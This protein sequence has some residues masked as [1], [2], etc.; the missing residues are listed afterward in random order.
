M[1]LSLLVGLTLLYISGRAQVI[2]ASRQANWS[3]ALGCYNYAVP[4]TELN[5]MDFGATGN[6]T[7]NDQPAVMAAIA[8]LNGHLGYIYFPPGNYLLNSPITLPDSVVLKG[9]SSDSTTLTFNFA[10]QPL[11]G[12]NIYGTYDPLLIQLNAGYVKDN[13]WVITDSAFL[14]EPGDYVEIIQNNGPWD[15]VPAEWAVNSV[16]QILRVDHINGDTIY[17]ESPLRI[18]Y[19]SALNPRMRKIFPRINAGVECIKLKRQDAAT[20]GANIIFS[21]AA[22]CFVRGVESD[23]SVA[24]HVDVFNSTRILVDGCYFHHAFEYDGGSKRGYGVTL[25][26]HTGECLVTNNIFRYLRHAMMVKTG[27]NGNVFSYNYSREVNRSEW[28][29]NYGGDISLHGHYPFANLFEGNI[30]QNIIID[31]YWGPSGPYNTFFRNRAETYGIILTDGNPTTS[32]YQHIVGNDVDY[33]GIWWI[34]GPYDITG[35][36]HI[37]HGNNIDG[38]IQPPGTSTLADTSYYLAEEP[39]FW[40]I[41]DGWPSLGIPNPLLTGSNPARTRWISPGTKTV[42]PLKKSWNGT[43]SADWNEPHNW[44]PYGVPDEAVEV[45]I[46]SSSPRDPEISDGS[47]HFIRSMKVLS[48]RE[49]VITNGSTLVIEK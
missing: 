7:T 10:T 5:V 46:P 39:V 14:F 42:C 49:V 2:Q 18:T 20:S 22:G 15:N 35:S 6:G 11:N 26:G 44:T 25:N 3:D 29:Y 30:V 47:F 28:P 21:Y 9:H 32:N 24:A 31:H 38:T 23:V 12:I 13:Q 19:E 34:G 8:A 16:G 45:T 4:V 36:N 27:A 17:L 43:V 1:K 40:D 33:N 48:G 37:Q 41:S